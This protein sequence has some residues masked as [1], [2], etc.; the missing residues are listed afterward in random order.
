MQIHY[1]KHHQAYVNGLNAAIQKEPSLSG[2]T[3]GE[4]LRTL[5]SV[6]ESVRTQVRNM[7]GG[8]LNHTIFW[9]TMGP[10]KGGEPSGDLAKE[11]AKAFKNFDAFKKEFSQAA[12]TQF[13][14]GWAWLVL[15]KKALQVVK[16]PNQ[17]SPYLN[18]M[19]PLL[20]LDVWEH[21]YYLKYK[22]ER[23]KYIEAWWN[24]VNWGAVA[25][26]YNKL[27]G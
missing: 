1:T 14:S 27:K 23:P 21:A 8:H 5:T 11:I 6:P 10:K 20:G 19:V 7:G 3:T 16:L 22:N 26:R 9:A 18:G 13:G 25:E 15:N 17:D 12:A 2:K 24:V 4:L